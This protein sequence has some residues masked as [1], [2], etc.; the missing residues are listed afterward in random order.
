MLVQIQL[1]SLRLQVKPC[2]IHLGRYVYG[3]LNPAVNNQSLSFEAEQR[4]HAFSV[5][6]KG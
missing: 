4:G 6:Q 2:P 1:C 3:G 5:E